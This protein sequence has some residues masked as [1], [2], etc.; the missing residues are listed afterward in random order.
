MKLIGNIEVSGITRI[1]FYNTGESWIRM[2]EP[3]DD[4]E[5]FWFLEDDDTFEK[6]RTHE[7]MMNIVHRKI[8]DPVNWRIWFHGATMNIEP[9]DNL[10]E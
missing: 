4:N 2:E 3:D 9:T 10:S 1:V 7:N 5:L 6:V 8:W